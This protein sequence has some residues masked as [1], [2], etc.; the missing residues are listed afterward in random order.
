M[1]V[2]VIAPDGTE[3]SSTGVDVPAPGADAWQVLHVPIT[4]VTGDRIRFEAVD[5]VTVQSVR[6]FVTTGPV[7]AGAIPVPGWRIVTVTADAVVLEP[8]P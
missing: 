8:A 5:P 1:V 4:T 2:T 7:E 6:G 3:R